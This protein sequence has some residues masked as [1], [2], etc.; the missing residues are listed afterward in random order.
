MWLRS[1]TMIDVLHVAENM[2]PEDAREIFAVG[3]TED[4][5]GLAYKL[6][7]ARAQAWVFLVAGLDNSAN[8]EAFLGIW[9]MD[10]TGGLASANLFATAAFP[11]LAAPLIRHVRRVIIPELLARGVR[12]VEARALSTYGTTRR[13][14]RACGAVCEKPKMPDYGKDGEAFAL[15]AWRRSDWE[16]PYVPGPGYAKTRHGRAKRSPGRCRG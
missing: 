7:G 15:Y 6:Y 3:R 4:R 5:V 14:L 9:P 1:P 2:R 8:G 16:T 12:R 13:F 11:H 10:E